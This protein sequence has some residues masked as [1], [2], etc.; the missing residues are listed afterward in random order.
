MKYLLIF[1][2]FVAAAIGAQGQ[3][4]GTAQ[5]RDFDDAF[6]R[7][8]AD[9]TVLQAE[10][11]SARAE[12]L[13]APADSTL[14]LPWVTPALTLGGYGIGGYTPWGD[15]AGGSSWRL[16]E[17][18][19]A[20]LGLSVTAGLGKHAPRGVGF[21][22]TAAF[23]YVAPLTA[24][25]SVAAGVFATNMDWGSWRRT[26][27]GFGGLLAYRLNERISLYA[28]GSKTFL[29]EQTTWNFQR[30]DPFPMF[31]DQPRDR[32]GVGAEFKVGEN[33]MIG[34]SVE[35]RTY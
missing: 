12:S 18:F 28:F 14:S 32:L 24:K 9:S 33:A 1:V 5:K 2:C 22:Q 25:L 20:Q 34:V 26:D 31:L 23:A 19:N 3:T 6:R 4:E 10:N 17:G 29:P 7:A 16:H 27:V 30:R 13:A 15:W 35:R 21:G 8:A 11:T